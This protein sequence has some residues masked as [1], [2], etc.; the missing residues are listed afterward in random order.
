[1]ES[2]SCP[3]SANFIDKVHKASKGTG[4]TVSIELCDSGITS[5]PIK[6]CSIDLVIPQIHQ[7]IALCVTYHGR[8]EGKH[9][10]S[11]LRT[12]AQWVI[13]KTSNKLRDVEMSN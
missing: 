3:Q 4:V 6:Q 7:Q 8:N 2:A 1:M 11:N 10:Y 5:A 12:F 13:G 9:G